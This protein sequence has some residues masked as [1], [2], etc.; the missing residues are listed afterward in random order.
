MILQS[1]IHSPLLLLGDLPEAPAFDQ[2]TLTLSSSPTTLNLNQKLGHLYED[3]LAILLEA[4][5]TYNLLAR[6]LQLHTPGKPTLGELDFLLRDLRSG[7]LIHLELATKFY[8]AVETPEGLTLPGPDSRDNF[9]SKLH[10]LRTHQLI[11]TEKHRHALPAAF[12][13]ETITTRHL[14]HGCIFDHIHS[15]TPACPEFVNPHR[16]QGR[17]LTITQLP[18][19]F[20]PGTRFEIIPK[21]LWPVPLSLLA[22]IPLEPWSA[23][24][25]LDRCTMLRIEGQ[26]VPHVITPATYPSPS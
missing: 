17:W 14:I 10:R 2:S 20:S 9:F 23:P 25:S 22:N 8:L 11:L 4:S 18:Q 24:T 26:T 15:T 7:Q 12:R 16:R 19:H 6:N 21:H 3:A 5:P 13:E 1:L